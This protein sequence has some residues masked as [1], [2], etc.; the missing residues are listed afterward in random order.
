MR[1]RLR[2]QRRHLGR[3]DE[4]AGGAELARAGHV[5]AKP[6]RVQHDAAC[7]RANGIQPP[8]AA[9]ACAHRI[10]DARAVRARVGV[11]LGQRCG[12]VAF[13][14]VGSIVLDW[15]TESNAGAT[16]CRGKVVLITGGAKRVGAAI[17]RRLH[18]AGAN[19]MLH[20]RASA[21]E[22]RLSAGRAQP[23]A[24]RTRSR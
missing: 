4:V 20:Y 2:E 5:I 9:I 16:V 14:P 17:C 23:R 21:G 6:R 11:G 13:A 19:L 10:D 22:A 3:R 18:A 8:R 1:E 12:R 15:T 7:N 24:R